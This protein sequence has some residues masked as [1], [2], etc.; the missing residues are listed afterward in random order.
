MCKKNCLKSFWVFSFLFLFVVF[1]QGYTLESNIPGYETQ[2]NPQTPEN[3]NSDSETLQPNL[4]EQK[5]L[6]I[7]PNN[8]WNSLRNWINEGMKGLDESAESLTMLENQLAELKAE[9]AAQESLLKQSRELLTYLR[10]NLAEA[11]NSVDVAIDRMQDA[12]SY[13]Q[14]IDAQNLLLKQEAAR[15]KKSGTIG[16]VFGGVTFGIGTPLIIEGIRADNS[17]M[18]WSGVGVTAAG[19]LV[20]V[21]G[22][23]VFGWW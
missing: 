18:L 3:Y 12:E 21:F 20:W 22:H 8:P 13:A 4:N 5:P 10:A 1:Q 14:Y 9:N 19:S 17:A 23:F 11:Q 7:D 15:L 2:S 16:F 6:L